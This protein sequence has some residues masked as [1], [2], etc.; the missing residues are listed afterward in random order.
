MQL[1]PNGRKTSQQS[2]VDEF[3]M[4]FSSWNGLPGVDACADQ[5]DLPP[6]DCEFKIED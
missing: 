1:T 6:L 4:Y 3:S 2:I 5:L